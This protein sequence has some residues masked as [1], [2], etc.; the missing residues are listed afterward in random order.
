VNTTYTRV[1]WLGV[2]AITTIILIFYPSDQWIPYRK[3]EIQAMEGFP[4]E[5]LPAYLII[6]MDSMSL[7]DYGKWIIAFMTSGCAHCKKAATKLRVN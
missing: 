7:H 6:G 3:T 2:L 5:L 4:F 1:V